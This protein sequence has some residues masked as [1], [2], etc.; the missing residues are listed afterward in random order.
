[1]KMR[2]RE[3]A[4]LPITIRPDYLPLILPSLWDVFARHHGQN[5][6]YSIFRSTCFLFLFV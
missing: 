3:R 6:A 4:H 5:L 1:L 2:R